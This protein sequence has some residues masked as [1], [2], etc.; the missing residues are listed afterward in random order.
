[1]GRVY[2]WLQTVAPLDQPEIDDSPDNPC[3]AFDREVKN[4]IN[5]TDIQAIQDANFHVSVTDSDE[6]ILAENSNNTD[7]DLV[8]PEIERYVSFV[9]LKFHNCYCNKLTIIATDY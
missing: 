5:R 2:N 6:E 4:E 9:I 3:F 7:D 8:D 1:M